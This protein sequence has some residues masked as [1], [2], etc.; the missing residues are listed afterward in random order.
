MLERCDFVLDA[1][2]LFLE[3]AYDHVVGMRS[4]EF[5]LN[6]GFKTGMLRFQGRNA[7]VLCQLSLLFLTRRLNAPETLTPIR[8]DCQGR[9]RA[10][11][12]TLVWQRRRPSGA[13][14]RPASPA[15]CLDLPGNRSYCEP[16]C[17]PANPSILAVLPRRY[18]RFRAS[19]ARYARHRS[20]FSGFAGEARAQD[21]GL[22][23]RSGSSTACGRRE[24]GEQ[25]CRAS[26]RPHPPKP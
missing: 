18:R 19:V 3:R 25:R 8:V 4:T 7:L 15:R 10:M 6:F 24:G 12:N 9:S 22:R 2:L 23:P 26:P 14:A 5:L 21:P 11:V 20:R 13:P 16:R 17:G 1:Q